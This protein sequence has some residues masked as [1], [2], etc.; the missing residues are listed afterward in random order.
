MFLTR[1]IS[2]L[3]TYSGGFICSYGVNTVY[4]VE[5]IPHPQVSSV[6]KHFI[7][8]INYKGWGGNPVQGE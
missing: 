6:I 8:P 1:D 2:C 7:T 5:Q 4:V 3:I